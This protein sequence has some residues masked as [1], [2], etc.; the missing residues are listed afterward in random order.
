MLSTEQS[1]TCGQNSGVILDT[2]TCL[3]GQL[4]GG[5]NVRAIVREE[6]S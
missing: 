4:G 3:N 6:T 2:L 5:L 1:T